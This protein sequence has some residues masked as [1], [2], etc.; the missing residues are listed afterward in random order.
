MAPETSD[1]PEPLAPNTF[2]FAGYSF[3]GWN[4]MSNG[5]GTVYGPGA[6]Y[7]F[8]ESATLYAQW[9]PNPLEYTV[10]FEPNGGEGTMFPE[11]SSAPEP[12]T[13]NAFSYSGYTFSGWNTAAN[14]TGTSYADQAIYPFSASVTLYAR[15]TKIT[16][17]TVTFNANGG[18]GSMA[19]ETSS[20][21]ATLT[22]NTFTR[23]G[24][25]FQDWNTESNGSGTAFLDGAYFPFTAS[26]T[27]YAQWTAVDAPTIFLEPT[28][29]LHTGGDATFTAAAS[30]SPTP[31]VQWYV[32][33]DGGSTWTAAAGATSS[34]YS[35][36]IGENNGFD[37][38]AVFTNEYGSATTVTVQLVILSLSTNWSGFVESYYHYTQVSAQWTVPTLTCD[39]PNDLQASQWVGIDGTDTPNYDLVQDG[40]ETD[41][42]G[43]TPVYGAWYEFLGDS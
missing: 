24:Y 32:S 11:Q 26:A 4:T 35:P 41:C 30:G 34:S 27:L 29:V 40:T 36:G 8:M 19:P 43:T 7:P 10:T 33:S 31:T 1:S 39:S 16:S 3:T 23:S 42:V 13:Q 15:W 37:Y 21:E 28:N 25:I 5:M 6:T 22:T 2:E 17:Y 12:L 14:G 18:T 20:V 38:R 9:T